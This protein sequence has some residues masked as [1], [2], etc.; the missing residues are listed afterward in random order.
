MHS[1][2]RTGISMGT[3]V[4]IIVVIAVVVVALIAINVRFAPLQL[5]VFGVSINPNSITVNSSA[6]LT[7]TVKSNDESNL[8]AVTV[9][10]NVTS[11]TFYLSGNLLPYGHDGLQYW[12]ITLQSSQQSTYSFKATGVLTGGAQT[13]TYSIRLDFYDENGTRFDTET[14]SLRVTSA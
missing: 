3:V 13:S 11:V 14:Q 8:H 2:S 7:F 1:R 4:I 10:F 5:Q 9:K 6:T 12:N